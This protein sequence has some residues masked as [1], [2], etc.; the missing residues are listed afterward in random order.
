MT[1]Y[2]DYV[3]ALHYLDYAISVATNFRQRQ[4]LQKVKDVLLKLRPKDGEDK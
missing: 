3:G 4:A 1:N 2:D